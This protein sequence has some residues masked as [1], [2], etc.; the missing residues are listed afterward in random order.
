MHRARNHQNRS[1]LAV[2]LQII[3][4]CLNLPQSPKPPHR[5]PLHLRRPIPKQNKKMPLRRRNRQSN[6]QQIK[7]HRQSQLPESTH[8]KSR[9]TKKYPRRYPGPEQFQ[10]INL[11]HRTPSQNKY[12][13]KIVHSNPSPVAPARPDL[14]RAASRRFREARF[15][16]VAIT[17]GCKSKLPRDPKS[18]H[19]NPAKLPQFLRPISTPGTIGLRRN[20][21]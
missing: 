6:R 3:R 1:N 11:P 14:R 10:S 7:L 8:L 16:N 19:A 17:R 15:D 2:P 20:S 21:R 4:Q 9:H 5:N 18:S 13:I 12:Q